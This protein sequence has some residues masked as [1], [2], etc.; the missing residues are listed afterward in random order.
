[1][2]SSKL[3]LLFDVIVLMLGF[4]I[5]FQARAMKINQEVP[6]L[7]VSPSEMRQCRN[8][9]GFILSLYPKANIFGIV[10]IIFGL[11]GVYNDGISA[12][13]ESMVQLNEVVNIIVLLIFV[14]VWIWFSVQ[15][16][17]AKEEFF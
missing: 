4:Y 2:D 15:L 1:M 3:M 14:A 9:K 16:R 13:N 12:M 6:S 5:L 10:D 7:F 8:K 11:E 17:K